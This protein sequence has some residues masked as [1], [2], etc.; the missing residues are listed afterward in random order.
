[1]GDAYFNKPLISKFKDMLFQKGEITTLGNRFV[2][3]VNGGSPFAGVVFVIIYYR[4][5]A[6]HRL[7]EWFL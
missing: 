3:K 7:L 4:L 1:M 5:M 6:A 2:M